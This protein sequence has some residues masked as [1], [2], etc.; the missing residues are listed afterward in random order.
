MDFLVTPLVAT[1]V[2]FAVWYFQSRLE[3]L[4]RE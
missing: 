3:A 2:G 4:R 1:L